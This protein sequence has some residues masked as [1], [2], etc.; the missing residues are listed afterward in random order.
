MVEMIFFSKVTKATV[1][2]TNLFSKIFHCFNFPEMLVWTNMSVMFALMLN[3]DVKFCNNLVDFPMLMFVYFLSWWGDEN[4]K[5]R[6]WFF[7]LSQVIL[8]LLVRTDV[9]WW[10]CK[11]WWWSRFMIIIMI[12]RL[13]TTDSQTKG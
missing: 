10:W 6:A 5:K 13:Q 8:A 3:I 9:C 1:S 4:A 12:S 7:S 11:W 2:L